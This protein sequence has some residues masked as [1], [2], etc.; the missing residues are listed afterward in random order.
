MPAA[1]PLEMRRRIV[2]GHRQG[3]TLRAISL[4]LGRAYV[5]VKGIWAHWVKYEK[6]TPNYEQARQRG[7]R[8]YKTVYEASLEIRKA[9]P[10]WGG[11]MIRL[12]LS[13]RLPGEALP[14]VRS[15]Q[16]WFRQ[17]GIG[18]RLKAEHKGG[19]SVKRGEHV[20]EVWAVDAKEKIRLQSGER[21][22]WLVISDEA[23]GAI[24]TATSFPPGDMGAS[25]AD[26]GATQLE[27][28]L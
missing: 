15:L 11:E 20:H 12:E 17:A 13:K 16:R 7:T 24:L 28:N 25:A 14:S 21:A 18:R 10:R 1:L 19:A 6:L 3:E 5:T 2:E 8:K 9:H 23:S 4:S 26:A 22:S 27:T